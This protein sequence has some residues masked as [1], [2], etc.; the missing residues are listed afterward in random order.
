VVGTY[1]GWLVVVSVAVAGVASFVALDMASQVTAAQKRAA[2]W[3][4]TIG[5]A[6]TIGAGIWSMHF[7]GMLAFTLPIP[8]S[9]DIPITGVSL[10]LPIVVSGFGLRQA[11]RP[12]VS[13]SRIL[14]SGL[15]VGLGIVA[16]HYT[17]M[18][19]MQM[20]PPIR[21]QPS[22]VGLSILIAVAGSVVSVWSSFKLRMETL[23]SA[24]MK[25]TGS[26]LMAAAGIVG[27]HY[28][29]IA[30]ARFAP[31]SVCTVRAQNI[32]SFGLAATVAGFC[33]SFQLMT[34]MISAFHAYRAE[35]ASRSA[36]SLRETAIDLEQQRRELETR[37]SER[38]AELSRANR[39]IV[40]V[41]E[42]ERQEL[43]R[44]LHDRVGQ[45][46]TALGI[47]LDI[48]RTQGLSQGRADLRAR[49]EDSIALVEATADAIENVMTEL[50]PPMLDD[51]GLLS[52]LQWYA[53]QFS[54]RT[55]IEVTVRGEEP[56]RRPGQE[57]E[58][59]LFRIA[60]EAL[61]N[62]AK[63]ARAAHV[64]LALEQS[65]TESVLSMSD[66]GVGF[67]PQALSGPGRGMATMRERAQSVGGYFEVRAAPNDGTR[68]MV[69]IPLSR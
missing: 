13:R 8:M 31:D 57:I 17:G 60:Q 39:K 19:A 34:L 43:S 25:K 42:S 58:I 56:A 22:L 20:Q 7:V 65:D 66:D 54:Q 51:H 67:D 32:D 6:I 30:A 5:G 55:G 47:N 24:V 3:A 48:L 44:E 10:L 18:A 12:M 40:E 59:T 41:Q 33:L 52:A 9:Y 35:Q 61:N 49:L 26:A 11:S 45:N 29:A 64:D 15:I 23:F 63:H 38:T 1:N 27:L 36:A 16:M 2:A 68:I 37:V 21:Y 14:L 46:L 62:V 53:K 50:R 4:W 69:R 28:T